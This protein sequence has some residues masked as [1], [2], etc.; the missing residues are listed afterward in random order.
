M[1]TLGVDMEMKTGDLLER[2][3]AC[4]NCLLIKQITVTSLADLTRPSTK[5]ICEKREEKGR[6][7]P[8]LRHQ[9]AVSTV[10]AVFDPSFSQTLSKLC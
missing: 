5:E 10:L 8:Q 7:S 3:L 9:A 1:I 4:E 2:W 6:K